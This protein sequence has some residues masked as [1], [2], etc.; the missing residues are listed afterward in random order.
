MDRSGDHAV[1]DTFVN[2]HGAE[3]VGIRHGVSG[4]FYGYAF[5]FAHFVIGFRVLP[6]QIR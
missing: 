5:V 2:H 1:G 3:V 6:D 4:H